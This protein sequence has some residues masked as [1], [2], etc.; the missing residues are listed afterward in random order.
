MTADNALTI[1]VLD[2]S[3]ALAW[4]LPGE[5]SAQA[6]RLRDLAVRDGHRLL[7]PPIF[8][9]EIANALWVASRRDRLSTDG[10]HQ[11]L[12]A[13]RDF[14]MESCDADPAACLSLAT[15]CRLAV[16]DAAYLVISLDRQVPLWSFDQ[17]LVSAARQLGITVHPS[18][19]L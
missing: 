18:A 6:M 16:S 3:V 13:L 4:V 15:Q 12:A 5:R 14:T 1:A 17:G 2:T 10:A 11:A 8:W 7:C 9:Y 19:E